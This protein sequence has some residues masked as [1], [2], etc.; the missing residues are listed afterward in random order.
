MR[1]RTSLAG[2]LFLRLR[3][4]FLGIRADNTD[5]RLEL[6]RLSEGT[7]IAKGSS[8]QTLSVTLEREQTNG[9]KCG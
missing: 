8:R 9:C 3:V 6:E 7:L 4:Q 1:A 5:Q 2:A